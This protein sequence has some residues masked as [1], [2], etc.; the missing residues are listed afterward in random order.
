[1]IMLTYLLIITN[2]CKFDIINI[3]LN[4]H[5]IRLQ[6]MNSQPFNKKHKYPSSENSIKLIPSECEKLIEA[7]QQVKH[8]SNLETQ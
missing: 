6:T 4:N 8:F 3:L 5:R 2:I 1:M 7:E